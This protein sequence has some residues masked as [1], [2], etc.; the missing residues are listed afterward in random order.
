MSS[1]LLDAESKISPMMVQWHACKEQAGD[2]ILL[3]RLG[4]FY[5]AFHE[6]AVL[7]AKELELTLTKRQDIPMSGVPAHSS[8]SYL[9]KL[10]SKGYKVAI[11]EQIEDPKTVKGLVKREVVR[12]LT[13]ATMLNSQLSNDKSNQFF[14]SLSQVGQLFGLAVIDLTTGEFKVVEFQ[15]IQGCITEVYRLQPAEILIS[16]RFFGAHTEILKQVKA[17]LNCLLHTIDEW[18]FAHETTYHFLNHHFQVHSLDGFGLKGLISSINAAGALLAYLKEQLCHSITH[19]QSICTYS[20]TAFLSLDKTTQKNLE[21]TESLQD[22]SRRHT[23]LE[24]L[25]Q[26]KTPMG[27]RLLKQWIKQPLLQVDLIGKRQDGIEAFLK[28]SLALSQLGKSLEHIR[29]LERLMMKISSSLASPKDLVALR[30]SLDAIPA[31]ATLLNDFSVDAIFEEVSKIK[32]LPE[33]T[34]MLSKAIV[35]EPPFKLSDGGVIRTGFNDDLDQLRLISQDSKSWIANYQTILRESSGIKTLKVGYTKAFG[36]YI[37]ISRGQS[38]KAPLSFQRRQTLTN[39]E[40]FI[41][42]ELKEYEEKFLHAEERILHLENELFTNLRAYLCQFLPSIL[43]MAQS[44]A[45]IDC[46]QSLAG[47]A[48]KYDYI[49]PFVDDSLILHIQEGRHPVI[50]SACLSERFIPNDTYLDQKLQR[51]IVITGPNMAGKSTYIRQVAL[52]TIMAQMGSF[53]PAKAAHIGIVD[54]VFTRIGASD[55]LSS[56]QSTF[57]VEMTETANILHHATSRSLV[58]L[59]EIGRGTSTYDGIS[60]AWSV[61]E[62]LLTT[63]G[64][65]AKTLFA[66]HYF[67]LTRLEERMA[68][69]INFHVAVHE[70]EDHIVF[71]RKLVKGSTDRSYGIHVARLA[72]L[73]SCLINRAKEILMHLEEM[74]NQKQVFKPPRSKRLAKQTQD[75]DPQSV[76]LSF[77][78]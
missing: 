50:E 76:Q 16:E 55:D 41:T 44:L 7:V 61:A 37:E 20:T 72:G 52:L 68:G 78:N 40:R 47:V 32:P 67:E 66:T 58:I 21:L 69:A 60:I 4:D 9:E 24:V 48:L 45:K 29:D 11:A 1:S 38:E 57:M 42:P 12:I 56:G 18:K 35:D 74:G 46:L 33:V 17:Q 5:E 51:L 26:T 71:L 49:R 14:I 19:I 65:M 8:E 53:I 10:V 75:S 70:N 73:P 28:N 13:P 30:Y 25:D 59:D 27:A 22:G 63:E 54:K 2:A 34:E 36:F 15:D 23:L 43:T 77:L 64:K 39:A 3:F 6:D 31:I 62:Y